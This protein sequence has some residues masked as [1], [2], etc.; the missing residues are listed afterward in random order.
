MI[1]Q[2]IPVKYEL[3]LLTET[4]TACLLIEVFICCFCGKSITVVIHGFCFWD[5]CLINCL[6]LTVSKCVRSYEESPKPETAVIVSLSQ[7]LGLDPYIVRVWFTNRWASKSASCSNTS[8]TPKWQEAEGQA[9]CQ[10]RFGLCWSSLSKPLHWGST[11]FLFYSSS[12]KPPWWSS[13]SSRNYTNQGDQLQ[14]LVN[15][16]SIKHWGRLLSFFVGSITNSSKL[17]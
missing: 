12:C 4:A 13:C 7:Q 10:W 1:D 16:C 8:P 9:N 2:P 3:T 11:S 6:A 17:L 14:D 15:S 5:T